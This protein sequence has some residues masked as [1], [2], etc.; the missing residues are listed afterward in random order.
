ME[1]TISFSVLLFIKAAC[2]FLLLLLVFFSTVLL[3]W[4]DVLL[5]STPTC[6]I[7]SPF[8]L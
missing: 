7:A 4:L 2:V 6:L 8:G 1:S 5:G 3:Q